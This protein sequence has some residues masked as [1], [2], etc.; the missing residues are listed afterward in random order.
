LLVVCNV[1]LFATHSLL[2]FTLLP[3]SIALFYSWSSFLVAYGS[4]GGWGTM[5]QTGNS[6]VWFPMRSLKFSVYLTHPAAL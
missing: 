6:L 3:S 1:L 4:V 2:L 5:L